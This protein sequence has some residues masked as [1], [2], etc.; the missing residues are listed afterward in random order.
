MKVI[1]DPYRGGTDVGK[2]IDNQY[3]KNIILNLSKYMAE[4]LNQLG[5]S[6]EL[7]R[8]NDISLTDEERN[9]IINEI[10]DRNDIIIQNRL[11]DDLDFDII[12]PLRNSDSLAS[13]ITRNLESRGINVDKYY[14]RRLPT[15]TTLDY[16]SII[17]NTNPNQTLIIEYKDFDNYKELV[18]IIAN[19]IGEYIKKNNTY[20]VKKGDSLYQI[21]LKYNTTVDK[22][23]KLN[24]LTNNSLSIGQILQIPQKEEQTTTSK[25]NIYIVQKGDTLYQ[26]ALKYN[27]T[28][29][30]LKK[31]N[32]L[33]SNT[34][35][36]NQKITLPTKISEDTNEYDY[37]TIQKGDSLYQIALKY[38]ITTNELKRI[39]NLSSNLLSIGQKLKVPKIKESYTI[40]TVQKGDSLYQ[41]AKKYNTTI[42]DIKSLN[43]L[44]SNLLNINQELKIPR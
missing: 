14:Q 11:S 34:L 44:T 6:T 37:Y 12:Y 10:K 22:I 23:K 33:T 42:N 19:S 2:Q 9:S 38:N 40:Y 39:N 16:Y 8:N 35:S 4:K 20:T 36:I 41:I 26:I 29:D 7:V 3:E 5:I 25:E 21:A 18:E 1:I 24:N 31:I 28:V 32:N 27:T 13:L 15:N 43:N 30:E 17:R